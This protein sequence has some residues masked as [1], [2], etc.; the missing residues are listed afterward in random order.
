MSSS[1]SIE[2]YNPISLPLPPSYQEYQ[3]SRGVK[4]K[5]SETESS[6]SS[7][8]IPLSGHE[9]THDRFRPRKKGGVT[10]P[11]EE[12]VTKVDKLFSQVRLRFQT[13]RSEAASPFFS[14]TFSVIQRGF[15]PNWDDISLH[16]TYTP[17]TNNPFGGNRQIIDN[18][19]DSLDL[20]EPTRKENMGGLPYLQ[21]NLR[22]FHNLTELNRLTPADKYQRHNLAR[23]QML[24]FLMVAYY[25]L[26]I[27][28]INQGRT[29][30]QSQ[31][32]TQREA[33]EAA[34]HNLLP[35]LRDDYHANISDQIDRKLQPIRNKFR[36]NPQQNQPSTNDVE[37][38]YDIMKLCVS[39]GMPAREAQRYIYDSLVE[40]WVPNRD[41]LP[42]MIRRYG[43]YNLINEQTPF[44]YHLNS[45]FVEDHILNRADDQLEYHLRPLALELLNQASITRED[46]TPWQ[47]YQ[48]FVEASKTIFQKVIDENKIKKIFIRSNIQKLQKTQDEI[49]KHYNTLR[50]SSTDVQRC[51]QALT[52]FLSS[53]DTYQGALTE[54]QRENQD[55]EQRYGDIVDL[56]PFSSYITQLQN[57]R[58]QNHLDTH[59]ASITQLL[60][61]QEALEEKIRLFENVDTL[62]QQLLERT[63]TPYYKLKIKESGND[64]QKKKEVEE[65]ILRAVINPLL[66]ENSLSPNEL[67]HLLD[68]WVLPRD[69]RSTYHI[70]SFT[71][72][73]KSDDDIKGI[74]ATLVR[75]IISPKDAAGNNDV[76][77]FTG[78]TCKVLAGLREE[79]TQNSTNQTIYPIRVSQGLQSTPMVHP[80]DNLQNSVLPFLDK[81]ITCLEE[82]Q[83]AFGRCELE[84]LITGMNSSKKEPQALKRELRDQQIYLI[85]RRALTS[86]Q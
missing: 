51:K 38:I 78:E 50:S 37:E 68:L 63:N 35:Q 60:D 77:H 40:S 69:R 49:S 4:R 33:T 46:Q 43:G 85:S 54:L 39:L 61:K 55:Y 24:Y 2:R 6:S 81:L 67:R 45:T 17:N 71:Q 57:L 84:E 76:A 18:F 83:K 21:H 13:E 23:F 32:G 34:H 5:K 74:T 1:S 20:E 79:R 27:R 15:E 64:G 58:A 3:E 30:L 12:L 41:R 16:Q 10:T 42:D 29:S 65:E 52:D 80:P 66:E 36:D 56:T 48:Q 82:Q 72:P 31:K 19:S 59:L 73:L 9:R 22:R 75:R 28:H 44:L 7:H 47:Y 11:Q 14:K 25:Q 62:N 8:A 70:S 26:D 53:I 86:T